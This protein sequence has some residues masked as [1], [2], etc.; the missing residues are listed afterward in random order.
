MSWRESTRL[1]IIA[2]SALSAAGAAAAAS[3]ITWRVL[4]KKYQTQLM[5][6]LEQSKIF[7]QRM[8]STPTFVAEE[9]SDIPPAEEG[10]K[11]LGTDTQEVDGIPVDVVGEALEKLQVYQGNRDDSDDDR[12]PVIINNIFANHTPPGEEVLDALL[13]TRDPS[14]PYI[15]TKHEFYTNEEDFEQESFTFYEGDKILVLDKE[16]YNPVDTERLAGDENLLRFGY[17][18]GDEDVV[19]IR[20]ETIDP[21]LDLHITR[22]PDKYGVVVMGLDNDEPHLQHSNTQTRRFRARDE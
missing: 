8:Y 16:E 3:V 11:Q 2:S 4:E 7:Y 22:S 15:I 9:K 14:E 1:V 10:S 17:G 13:A 12:R 5:L 18:S 6:E 21:P 19:Y 20:N